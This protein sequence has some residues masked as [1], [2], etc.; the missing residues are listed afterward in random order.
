MM[1]HQ[2]TGGSDLIVTQASQR[3]KVVAC[4]IRAYPDVWQVVA[5]FAGCVTDHEVF[6]KTR[7]LI[8]F[9]R[10]CAGL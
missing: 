5:L 4:S 10:D 6:R 7:C 1:L 3:L 8:R 2:A 9:S